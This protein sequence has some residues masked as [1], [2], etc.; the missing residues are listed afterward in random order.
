MT[1]CAIILIDPPKG[2]TLDPLEALEI[3]QVAKLLG[4]SRPTVLTYVKSGELP[5]FQVGSCRRIRRAHVEEFLNRHTTR[6]FERYTPKAQRAGVD[7]VPPSV[8][9]DESVYKDFSQS[10]GEVIPF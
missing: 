8:A 1:R 3:K 7:Q 2:L 6:V 9:S 5:T 4:V 10:E